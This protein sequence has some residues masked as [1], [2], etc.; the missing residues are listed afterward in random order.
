MNRLL[1]AVAFAL[2]AVA[3]AWVGSGFLVSHSLAL[4]VTAIIG[5][6]Y[7]IGGVEM[8][9]FRRATASLGNALTTTGTLS[10]LESLVERVHPSLQ[11]TVRLRVEGERV[12]LPG[13]AL[14]PYLVGLLVMLGMLGTFIGMVAT[15]NGAVFAL[16]GTTDLEAIR[17]GLAAP[18]KGL[19]LAFGTSVAGVAA[20]A[21]LGLVSTLARRERLVTAQLLDRKIASDLRPFSLSHQRQETFRAMQTQA[22]ALPDVV[23]KLHAMA[24]M[25]ERMGQQLNE[26]LTANQESFHASTRDLYT[27]LAQSVEKSLKETLG[28]S[29][30]LAGESLKPILT[31]AM[32][33]IHQVAQQ[34]QESLSKAAHA[35]LDGFAARFNETASAVTASWQQA[36]GHHEQSSQAVVSDLR[37]SLNGFSDTFEA[38]ASSL[39]SNYDQTTRAMRQDQ[40]AEAEK[41]LAQWAASA[42]AITANVSRSLQQ[43]AEQSTAQQQQILAAMAATANAITTQQQQHAA[44]Q[45]EEMTRLLGQSETLLRE[46]MQAEAQWAQE[47]R[48]TH[49][50]LITAT[51]QQLDSVAARF[52]QSVS[53]VSGHWQSALSAQSQTQESLVS[54]LQQALAGFN[55]Q[56]SQTSTA[57]LA[58]FQE[59]ATAAHNAQNNQDQQR[60]QQW[61]TVLQQWT[62]DIKQGWQSAGQ[63]SVANQ[64]AICDVLQA[65]ANR[66]AAQGEEH[67]T[68]T[69]EKITQLL[70][71]SEQLV[72]SRVASEQQW[73]S[74]Q[75]DHMEQLTSALRNE[76][77]Q[78]RDEEA[79]RG[80]AAVDQLGTLQQAVAGHLA[81]LGAA[82]EAPMTQL[83]NTASEAP[84]AAAEVITQLRQEISNNM[85]RDNQLLEERTR[86]MEGLDALLTSLNTSTTEQRAAIDTLV[87]GSAQQLSQ[88]GEQF[89]AQMSAEASK[90][91][92]IA[93]Q[94]TGS[95]IE[96][97]SLSEAFGVAVQRFNESNEKLIDNLQRIEAS[98]EK[99]STRSD[100]QLAYYVAQAREIIDLSML[101]QREIFEGL[102]QIQGSKDTAIAEVS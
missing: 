19:G 81:T 98:M 74:Q 9:L 89:A 78:L 39:L 72:Q 56:L 31:E 28:E 10:S 99:S 90:L 26:R 37:Q 66:M 6:V 92:D 57:L 51:Q 73:L 12:A 79:S 32:S 61:Q 24:Q 69:L 4:T 21:M 87:S 52:N 88:V 41:R 59:A 35:Q 96:V 40:S 82:L 46:R 94:V 36:L 13:P 11:S 50:A 45:L 49:A 55:Q 62:N 102:R 58:A 22:Q 14:T 77:S 84:R 53:D 93:A 86:I 17:A 25:M 44:A 23:D 75:R 30:R 29:G 91:T 3:I 64:Q 34:T 97:S 71:A 42:D 63:Q 101:S 16:E 8:L 15:L 7:L 2:G 65:T 76:L 27:G 18:I 47:A 70:G 80:K 60:L 38:T 54:G 1:S 33:S 43:A 85:A 20:S 67:A 100:E 68:H 5:V 95:A 48:N 83:I